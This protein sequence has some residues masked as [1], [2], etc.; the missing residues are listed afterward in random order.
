MPK[1]ALSP[2]LLEAENWKGTD[3]DVWYMRWRIKLK[4]WFAYGP[5]ATEWW[6]KWREYPKTLFAV[7]GKQ[8]FF[9]VETEGWERDTAWDSLYDADVLFNTNLWAVDTNAEVDVFQDGY[10]SRVQ[11]YARWSFQV[12][13]PFLVA[14]HVY[15][16][17]EDVPHYGEQKDTDGKLL[18]FYIGAH[19]DADKVYWFPSAFLGF[20]WK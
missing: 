19:R 6:A 5:R 10:L 11:K 7:K 4:H 18:F 17:A 20:V 2:R 14:F 8:G 9:R 3:D 1:S 12:Q 13:W 15:R 16:R